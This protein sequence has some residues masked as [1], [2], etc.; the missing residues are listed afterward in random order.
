M[1][2]REGNLDGPAKRVRLRSM[3]RDEFRAFVDR[4]T[5]RYAADKVRRGEWTEEKALEAAR[6]FTQRYLPNGL[7][8]PNHNLSQLLDESTGERV[9]EVW[10]GLREEGGKMELWLYWIWIEPKYRRRGYAAQVLRRLEDEARQR[11]ADRLGLNV[12]ADNAAA[13]ALYRRLGFEPSSM[14]MK[15]SLNA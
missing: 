15:R 10:Y 1:S 5:P 3:T 6:A 11:G 2:P 12:N 8:T 7:D 14:T 9:G 13:L 4:D